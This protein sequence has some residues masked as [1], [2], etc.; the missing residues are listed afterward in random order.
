MTDLDHANGSA[1]ARTIVLPDSGVEVRL[2]FVGP[3][4]MNDIRKAAEKW[5]R[6]QMDKPTAPMITVHY[7][8]GD[9]QEA[10]EA[11]RDYQAA[12][13]EFNLLHG[14]RVVE[15][16]TKYGAEAD[17][18]AAAIAALRADADAD[19]L[20]LPADDRELYL[21]RIAIQTERDAEA[22]QEAILGT[23]QP[24]EKAVAEKRAAFPSDVQRD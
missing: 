18:D 23:S 2:K 7:E 12:L 10:N 21:T 11:D 1:P 19:G 9:R 3:L 24:T 16:L 17:V 4:L 6:K 5:A 13:S 14:M 15:L 22:L 20:E 8:Q